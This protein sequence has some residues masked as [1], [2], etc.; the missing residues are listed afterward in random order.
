MDEKNVVNMKQILHLVKFHVYASAHALKQN[1]LW[2]ASKS[3]EKT[4]NKGIVYNTYFIEIK[5]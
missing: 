4:R 3:D 2:Y 1:K 5:T